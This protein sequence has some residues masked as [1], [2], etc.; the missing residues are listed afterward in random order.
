MGVRILDFHDTSAGL[1]FHGFIVV[2]L[3]VAEDDDEPFEDEM[4]ALHSEVVKK[5]SAT[6]REESLNAAT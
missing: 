4:G 6:A 2:T 3:V 1:A 5:D